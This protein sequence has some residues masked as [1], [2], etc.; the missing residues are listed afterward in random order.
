MVAGGGGYRS[1][2]SYYYYGVSG[3]GGGSGWVNTQSNYTSWNSANTTDAANYKLKE[4]YRL[5]NTV[6]N[7][8]NVSFTSPIGTSETGHTGNG[9]VRI[10][11]I[12]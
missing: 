8:G 12:D 11:A 5:A 1:N 4:K 10:T 9:Y 7:E 2:S 3:G 6:L